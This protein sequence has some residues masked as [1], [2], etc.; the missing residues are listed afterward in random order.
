MPGEDASMLPHRFHNLATSCL[1]PLDVS[2][3]MEM[4]ETPGTADAP[5]VLVLTSIFDTDADFL[6]LQLAA[7]GYASHRLNCEQ[8]SDY[9]LSQT[10]ENGRLTC[11]LRDGGRSLVLDPSIVVLRHFGDVATTPRA[12]D[13]ESIFRHAQRNRLIHNLRSMFPCARWINPAPAVERCQNRL[14][15]IRLAD[16]A[17]FTVPPTIVTNDAARAE[18]FRQA[19][20]PVIAKAI[21]HHG[22]RIGSM[23]YD[24]HGSLV[25]GSPGLDALRTENPVLL[26]QYLYK[27]AEIR[28]FV[29]GDAL[30]TVRITSPMDALLPVDMHTTSLASY[31]Y[32]LLQ[33]DTSFLRP[34]RDLMKT[35]GLA[36]GAIDLLELRDGS[37]V[38]LEVNPGGDWM[39]IES[40]TSCGITGLFASHVAAM[41]RN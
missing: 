23:L 32:E 37:V 34:C 29:V 17:G 12:D 5:A 27:S 7:E 14:L 9:H 31:D 2:R 25:D 18:K 10:F 8:L 15:Q 38:F 39:W 16:I 35:L 40:Q 1:A 19:H 33:P 11:E 30:V 24:F 20:G 3:L 28:V 41:L 22:I 36:Y 6:Q 4:A 26:Q 13:P 21:G